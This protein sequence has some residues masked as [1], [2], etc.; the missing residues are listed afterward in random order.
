M[1]NNGGLGQFLALGIGLFGSFAGFERDIAG[2]EADANFLKESG[3]RRSS[4][5]DPNEVVGEF[6]L[7][8]S[9]IEDHGLRFE[10]DRI[11]V[12]QDLALFRTS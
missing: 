7:L 10:L 3:G 9:N 6:L 2:S 11:R 12:E 4:G 8:A 5:E 1:R